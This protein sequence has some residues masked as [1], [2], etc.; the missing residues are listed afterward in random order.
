MRLV[1]VAFNNSKGIAERDHE[2][3][4]VVFTYPSGDAVR[5]LHKRQVFGALA[6]AVIE[7]LGSTSE[8]H[9]NLPARHY[10]D[11]DARWTSA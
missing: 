7:D 1:V 6:N 8:R 5:R 10:R 9:R 4:S 3:T 11:P 2:T